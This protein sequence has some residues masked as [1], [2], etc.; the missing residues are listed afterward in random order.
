MSE[1]KSESI[2]KP[3]ENN[4]VFLCGDLDDAEID[5]LVK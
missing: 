5:R 4:S 1:K 3:L 2:I